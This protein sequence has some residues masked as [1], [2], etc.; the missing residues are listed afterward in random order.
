VVDS[1]CGKVLDNVISDV[2]S[3]CVS[4]WKLF[5]HGLPLLATL[6]CQ[7]MQPLEDRDQ[8]PNYT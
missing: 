1:F 6:Q 5:S 8:R 2:D 4:L 7:R 3:R